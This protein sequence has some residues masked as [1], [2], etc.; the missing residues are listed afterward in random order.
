M[1]KFG[2]RGF[3]GWGILMVLCLFFI[4]ASLSV[5]AQ[6]NQIPKYI[7]LF[8]GDGM[9][10]PQVS[11]AEMFLGNLRNLEGIDVKSLSFTQFP[12]AGTAQTFDAS[13]FVPDS[14]STATSM[15]SGIKTLS[16]V[17]NMDVTKTY[18]V[19]PITENLRDMGYKIGIISSV[20]INHATPA[21]FYAKVSHR[22]MYYEIGEQLVESGFHYFGGGNFLQPTG[23]NNDQPNIL[24][25]ARENGY[26]IAQTNQDILSLNPRLG[27]VIAINPILDGAALNYELDRSSGELAL[28]DFVR[29]GIEVLH[30]PD[31]YFL[32]V[33]SGKIDWAGHANDA[34]ASIYDTIAFNEAIEE[35]LKVYY[36]YPQ[37]TLIIVTGDHEC[38][39]MTIG[40]AG[41]AYETFFQVIERVTMTHVEFNKIVNAYRDRTTEE[42][43]RLED[44]LPQI[45]LAYGLVTKTDPLADE[46]PESVLTDSEINRL[47]E[48]L[49]QTM[50]PREERDYTD[51]ERIMYGGYEPLTITLSHIVNNKAGMHYTSFAHTGLPVPVYAIGV[52]SQAFTGFYDNT[53][54]YYKLISIL[55][56]SETTV[57][58]ESLQIASN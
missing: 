2:R 14:A 48:A 54:I 25:V 55:G 28:S 35:A 8:I 24:D 42:R 57:A 11:S 33:E 1:L 7:F 45:R 52:G 58:G 50:T 17:I 49:K 32:M 4:V 23:R 38:G 9:S 10:Y 41:T 51:Q 40:F 27:K 26:F 37:E 34:A 18:S 43:A 29:K 15:A 16:G 19:T 22:G 39:G 3:S 31:G 44:L 30:N 21:A 56:I 46:Y 20:P 6:Q 5:S 53:G 12:V 36:K 47:R 13:S